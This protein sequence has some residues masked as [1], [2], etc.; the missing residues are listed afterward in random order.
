MAFYSTLL[1]K[2]LA[3][4]SILYDQ[5]T[6]F[7]YAQ[8][9]W[10]FYRDYKKFYLADVFVRPLVMFRNSFFNSQ[11][12]HTSWRPSNG[13]CTSELRMLLGAIPWR[14]GGTRRGRCSLPHL[15]AQSFKISL[16]KLE[17]QKFANCIV[18][19]HLLTTNSKIHFVS[20]PFQQNYFLRREIIFYFT[21]CQTDK[22]R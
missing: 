6:F 18:I 3:F 5:K 21:L 9:N 4:Y 13:H 8:P 11:N 17:K 20:K 10:F 19:F 2:D 14:A 22:K 1:W 12:S 16:V 15:F 7:L